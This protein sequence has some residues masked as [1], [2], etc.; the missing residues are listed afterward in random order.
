M[1]EEKR[2]AG[3]KAISLPTIKLSDGTLLGELSTNNPW[4]SML[5][6]TIS[7]DEV[8]TACYSI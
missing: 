2:L 4:L 3:M 7:N 8:D 5:L 6:S 1:S